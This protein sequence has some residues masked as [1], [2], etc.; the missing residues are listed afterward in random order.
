MATLAQLLSAGTST[1]NAERAHGLVSNDQSG[2][3][4][5]QLFFARADL[6]KLDLSNAEFDDCTVSDTNFRNADL[7][8]AY[9]HGGR[10]ERCDFRGA[11]LDGAT[12]EQ[13]EFVECDFSGAQG[14]ASV[15]LDDVT[16]F[17]AASKTTAPALNEEPRFVT[18]RVAVNPKLEAELDASPDDERRWLVYGDW[19]Q[20]EGDVR[21]ELVTRFQRGEGFQAFVDEHL[22]AL[23]GPCA[24]EVRGG[25]EVPELMP[26]WRHGFVVGATIGAPN[27]SR[28]IDLG[29]L[30][31]RVLQLP[32]CRFTPRLS[33]GLRHASTRRGNDAHDYAPLVQALLETPELPR[34]R[35]LE[36][37]LQQP[38]SSEPDEDSYEALDSFEPW[39]DLSAMWA[40]VPQLTDLLV[41]G[42]GGVLGELTLP[43]LKRFALQCYS[44]DEETMSEVI[45]AR[46]P[47]LER[48]ELWD[49][50]GSV[51][52]EPL[53]HA[54]AAC[55]LTHFGLPH[56]AQ[57]DQLL[58][59]LVRTGLLARL[60]VLDLSHSR[61]QG[62]GFNYLL[63]NFA[64][65]RHLERLDLTGAAD[66]HE[67][68]AL[69]KLGNFMVFRAQTDTRPLEERTEL[70]A[71]DDDYDFP[72]DEE[73]EDPEADEAPA[74][75]GA[76]L[77]IP[78]E[79]GDE[80]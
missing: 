32:V 68:D 59:M 35:H 37:G 76:D 6:S 39:G 42:S 27:D 41:K 45:A 7:R 28:V 12:F 60:K 36:F 80:P 14:L 62:Q 74:A 31:Q 75:P 26:H 70:N 18:G 50:N 21:G 1:F 25:G 73:L 69:G 57:L 61:L 29:E 30:T 4:L 47:A 46:W 51:E 40:G 77:D 13:L 54:L 66:Q 15:E 34:L 17:G 65:F 16:G 55:P 79:Y 71:G 10:Y 67:E 43:T 78:D 33:Y 2:T 5:T 22:E 19:L 24:D 72:Q 23:F 11:L 63:E 8:G 9:L 52:L 53:L 44:I 3:T 48:F 49:T 64:A 20:S 56:T 38:Q 58:P